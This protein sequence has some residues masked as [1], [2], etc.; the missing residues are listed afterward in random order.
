MSWRNR[1]N[2][3]NQI[4]D[5][6]FDNLDVIDTDLFSEAT[7]NF[8]GQEALSN[9][10]K[11]R[12]QEQLQQQAAERGVT[13]P[14]WLEV[15]DEPGFMRPT[16]HAAKLQGNWPKYSY[17]NSDLTTAAINNEE[18][19][20]EEKDSRKMTVVKGVGPAYQKS[21]E[22]RFLAKGHTGEDVLER[23]Q[24]EQ[25]DIPSD[26][27]EVNFYSVY[28]VENLSDKFA[29]IFDRV[30]LPIDKMKQ[31]QQNFIESNSEVDSKSIQNFLPPGV[32]VPL[33]VPETFLDELSIEARRLLRE[34]L[35]G[36]SSGTQVGERRNTLHI[37]EADIEAA[38]DE[39]PDRPPQSQTFS[40]VE[41]TPQFQAAQASSFSASTEQTTAPL[42]PEI[43][44]PSS[45]T[46]AK[47]F[48]IF[49]KAK[50]KDKG[51][52]DEQEKPKPRRLKY[53]AAGLGI[54]VL[55]AGV[56]NAFK[57]N[58]VDPSLDVAAAKEA[59]EENSKAGET[60]L[61]T[62]LEEGYCEISSYHAT[63]KVAL[64][65]YYP[66]HK[67][68]FPQG[69]YSSGNY[70]SNFYFN[71]DAGGVQLETCAVTPGVVI[72]KANEK[73]G[74]QSIVVD[75][76]KFTTK[77]LIDESQDKTT[78][79]YEPI[80]QEK[81]SEDLP[82][83]GKFS[84]ADVVAIKE[85]IEKA[86]EEETK[87]GLARFAVLSSVYQ[88]YGEALSVSFKERITEQILEQAEAQGIEI[89][90]DDIKFKGQRPSALSWSLNFEDLELYQTEDAVRIK[91]E[92]ASD[93]RLFG[94]K[95][96]VKVTA[97]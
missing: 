3:E 82:V 21:V 65:A 27:T 91:G 43:D 88:N 54:L 93:Y 90:E 83:Y 59:L 11:S 13:L 38:L 33:A 74:E 6:S 37:S 66:D 61:F 1:L 32:D 23:L 64:Q 67:A 47:E 58:E 62:W 4:I 56:N 45:K 75:A 94:I 17:L 41:Q 57:S 95:D 89:T 87:N 46:T 79:V 10:G 15:V 34:K 28:M 39:E 70:S 78:K 86:M 52:S 5:N 24:V 55:A 20:R 72:T 84:A 81:L 36:Q 31:T 73:T 76:D 29:E 8:Q 19:I 12:Q 44:L 85:K 7:T 60:A 26:S 22:L 9:E 35:F 50:S 96:S 71:I 30:G 80:D 40:S 53:A 42:T 97:E 77:P 92:P 63:G 68:W 69:D 48:P 49:S 2:A 16:S 14:G 25:I 51:L 18:I